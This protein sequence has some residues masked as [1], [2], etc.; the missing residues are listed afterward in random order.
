MKKII[1]TIFISLIL[2]FNAMGEMVELS[3]EEIDQVIG[4]YGIALEDELKK[5]FNTEKIPNFISINT[6]RELSLKNDFNSFAQIDNFNLNNGIE[7]ESP[8]ESPEMLESPIID[9][10][11]SGQH[12]STP[13]TNLDFTPT[14]E[15]VPDTSKQ[16][17][18][19]E[20][21]AITYDLTTIK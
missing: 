14:F 15:Y 16:E 8:I 10:S 9:F 13:A 7:L 11:N 20:W 21:P 5:I 19:Y 4:Q 3:S 17:F 12:I 18:V 6:I 1:F 2:S